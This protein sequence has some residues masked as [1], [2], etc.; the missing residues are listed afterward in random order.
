[1]AVDTRKRS[2]RTARA[3]GLPL[4]AALGVVGWE[5]LDPVLLAALATEAPLLLVGAHGTAK[6]LVAERVAAALGLEFRH[7]NASLLSYDDLVGIP[8][9]DESGL[10]LRFVGTPATVWGA[11]FVL[12]DEISRCRPDLQNKLFPLVHERKVAGVPLPVLRHRWAA[13][14]PPLA[15]DGDLLDGPGYLGAE[16]LDAALADRFPFVVRVPGWDE[17]DAAE[18][19]S[20][21]LGGG[22]ADAVVLLPALVEECSRLVDG[23]PTGEMGRIGDYAVAVVDQLRGANVVLSPRRAATL[24]RNIV[25]VHAAHVALGGAECD[26]EESASV[27]LAVSLPQTADAAEPSV[28]VVQGSHRQAWE[29]SSLRQ[30]DAWR[31]V[32]EQSD[33]VKRVALA[34]RLEIDDA[35]LAKLVTQA[36]GAVPAPRRPGLATALY[37]RFHMTRDLTAAAWEPVVGL[38][39]GVLEARVLERGLRRGDELDGWREILSSTEG[40]HP[41]ERRLALDGYPERWSVAGA[42][43]ALSAFRRDLRTLGVR[44]EEAAV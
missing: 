20:L 8:V 38:A 25:S 44:L 41:F 33:P 16:P 35:G 28:V 21:V 1:M 3:G 18:R 2:R 27:A 4:T 26:L 9:P 43:A 19:R 7:Y 11:E 14:N 31:Q 6:T 40:A 17:L 24:V 42:K 15:D 37:L 22:V 13:M 10:A 29:L 39:R 5:R 23:F 32:L 36:L 12:L 30:D 34:D